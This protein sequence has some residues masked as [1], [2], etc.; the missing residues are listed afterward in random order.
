ML[1]TSEFAESTVLFSHVFGPVDT[2]LMR[3]IVKCLVG[4]SQ[5]VGLYIPD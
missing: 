5:S 3:E 4:L 2:N 1:E